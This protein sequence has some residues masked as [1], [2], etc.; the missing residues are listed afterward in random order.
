[1]NS[2]TKDLFFQ[3]IRIGLGTDE[4]N[5]SDSVGFRSL[6]A[7]VAWEEIYKLGIRQGVTAI[8]FDGLQQLLG[9]GSSSPIA[10]P[11]SK[12]K[13]KW[14]AHARQVEQHCLSQFK[15][16]AELATIYAAHDI[17]I[18]VL[19]GIAAGMNYPQPNH[20][21][22]G[23]L[24]CF[25]MG[26]YERGNVVA[27]E[28]GAKV[29]RDFYKHSHI[30]YKGLSVENHQF[31]TGIRGSKR[32]KAFERLLQSLLKDEGTI[33]IGDT[34][35]ECPS[36]MFNA[37]FLTHHAQ[38]HFLSEGIVLRHLCDWTMLIY[39]QGDKIDWRQFQSFCEVY[40]M[41]RFADTMTRLAEKLLHV[42]VPAMYKIDRNDE[43]D[44]YLL[45][46]MLYGDNSSSSGS[47]WKQRIDL[48]KG[49]SNHRMRYKVFSDTSFLQYIA[50]LVYG[51]CFD[52]NPRL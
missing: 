49:I 16:S 18:V 12:L 38:R 15:L 39:R 44:D 17:R 43:L 22:C 28:H 51:F 27:E 25:L 41:R 23:D 6:D 5:G 11:D 47:L 10:Q 37:L 35:L 31:C 1:M 30:S 50:Q 2:T 32:T 8:Q 45:H 13:L 7:D 34:S 14:F 36:P 20:R 52:R 4:A 19:K 26:D 33:K 9:S 21:P 42:R 40:G 48:I 24:D 3:L 29:K 46:E